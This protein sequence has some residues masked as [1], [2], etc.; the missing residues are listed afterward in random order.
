MVDMALWFIGGWALLGLAGLGLGMC[1]D[2]YRFRNTNW[3]DLEVL[4]VVF[5][6]A[7]P[8]L[9]GVAVI[10]LYEQVTGVYDVRNS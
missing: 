8:L 2:L 4:I 5:P 1:T 6:V 9:F 10:I 3:T 7:G